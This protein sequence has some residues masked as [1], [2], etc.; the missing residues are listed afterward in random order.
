MSPKTR[1]IGIEIEVEGTGPLGTPVKGWQVHEEGSLRAP[2][3]EGRGGCE[4]VTHGPIMT[5]DV[6]PA[7]DRLADELKK[8]GCVVDLNAHRTSTHI[9][10]N[11]Q[12]LKLIELLGY[13]TV[14]TAVEPLFLNL[15]GEGRDGNSFCISSHE[16]GDM[17]FYF[18]EM[19]TLSNGHTTDALS[20][21]MLGGS[22]RP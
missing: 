21:S 11:V 3:G 13:L 15:C 10:L 20:K 5:K 14:F 9:H 19:L 12:S 7:V 4:Y 2:G 17:P 1:E 18:K 6:I 22:T 16:T 8:A